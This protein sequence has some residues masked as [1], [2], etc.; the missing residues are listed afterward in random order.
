LQKYIVNIYLIQYYVLFAG[1][2]HTLFVTLAGSILN[3]AGEKERE[4]KPVA[5]G[6]KPL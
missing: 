6:E 4:E 3:L 5:Y 2:S 1:R